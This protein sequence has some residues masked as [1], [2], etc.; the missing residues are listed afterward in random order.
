MNV[1]KASGPAFLGSHTLPNIH[2]TFRNTLSTTRTSELACTKEPAKM[3][4]SLN[5][6]LELLLAP[7]H[8]S[9]QIAISL[10]ETS[11][12][13]FSIIFD[14]VPTF[15]R[16]PIYL[17]I[18]LAA[19]FAK[20]SFD[21]FVT[22]LNLCLALV[23]APLHLSLQIVIFSAKASLLVFTI[24]LVLIAVAKIFFAICEALGIIMPCTIPH[25]P[26]PSPFL[27]C[28][29]CAISN[30]IAVDWIGSLITEVGIAEFIKLFQALCTFIIAHTPQLGSF[31]MELIRVLSDLVCKLAEELHR[32]TINL[33]GFV[34]EFA[35]PLGCAIEEFAKVIGSFLK[36]L[37]VS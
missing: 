7:L 1:H 9:L 18:Q 11:V 29:R 28:L 17:S 8:F 19:L 37:Q 31:I 36:F 26:P 23:L 16:A 15:L 32:C 33:T 4:S 25:L 5:L 35:K 24:R 22:I 20:I 12:G 6:L 13:F 30:P 3:F 21:F 2:P 34:M 14:L 10:A 27:H